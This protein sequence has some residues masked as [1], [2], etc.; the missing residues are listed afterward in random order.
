MLKKFLTVP[1]TFDPDDRRRRQILNILL[2][3]FSIIA[4]PSFIASFFGVDTHIMVISILALVVFIILV[5]INHS[6]RLPG[7][8]S[9]TIFMSFLIIITSQA[10][11]PDELYNGRSMI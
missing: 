4:I 8:I 6:P 1:D 9:A 2:I 3:S 11:N 5:F 7:W 10:D